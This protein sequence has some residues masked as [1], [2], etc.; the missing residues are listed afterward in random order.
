M[1][2][3]TATSGVQQSRVSDFPTK[4]ACLMVGKDLPISDS[5]M[6][7]PLCWLPSNP[8]SITVLLEEG[9]VNHRHR[10]CSSNLTTVD[11]T[12]D[13]ILSNRLRVLRSGVCE[14]MVNSFFDFQCPGISVPVVEELTTKYAFKLNE[15]RFASINAICLQA[16]KPFRIKKKRCSAYK[17]DR[18]IPRPHEAID[19]HCF[20]T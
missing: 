18:T 4:P 15:Y 1:A 2:R 14:L 3:R 6:L 13:F 9:G 19:I 8:T 11:T 10:A 20:S 7:R 5:I 16:Q 17:S 12:R